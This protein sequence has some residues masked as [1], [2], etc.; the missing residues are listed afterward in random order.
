MSIT[1]A[2]APPYSLDE[3]RTARFPERARLVSRMWAERI[4]AVPFIVVVMYWVKYLLLFAGG[5]RF[6]QRAHGC[7][8]TIVSGEVAMENDEPAGAY[9]GRLIRGQQA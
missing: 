1:E 2:D 8:A 9:P 7:R 3:L 4:G 6:M 5:R